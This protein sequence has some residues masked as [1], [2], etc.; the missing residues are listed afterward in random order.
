MPIS[1]AKGTQIRLGNAASPST[2][3]TVA[4][5]RSITGPTT[6]PNVV[7]ITAHDTVGYW[8]R[9]IAVL[10][11]PGTVGFEVNL[12]VADATHAFTTGFWSL[13]Q[14]LTLRQYQVAFPNTA[15]TLT[16]DAYVSG[17]EFG[18]PVDNVLSAKI[19]L[20]IT[21]AITAS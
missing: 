7:D 11:D 16:F 4:Q 21:D 15:G 19:E 14:N 1:T 20:S 10:I 12:D 5:V 13:M 6:K 2:Y 18:A 17:H 9:K 8:R 3:A